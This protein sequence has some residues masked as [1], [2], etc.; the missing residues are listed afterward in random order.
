MDGRVGFMF[1]NIV[2]RICTMAWCVTALAAAAWYLQQG[3][4]LDT[5]KPDNV[6]GDVARSFL[7]QVLPGLLGVF[8][9]SL[10]ASVMSSCDAFMISSSGLFTEDI[11]RPL[12]PHREERHYLTVGRTA[13]LLVVVGGLLF[14]WWVPNVVVALNI[15]FKIAPMMGIVFWLGLFWRRATPIGAWAATIAGFSTWWLTT[16]DEVVNFVARLP[17]ADR[18]GM[19]SWSSPGTPSVYEPWTIDFYLTCALMAGVVGSLLSAPVQR[20]KLDTFYALIRTPIV[21]GEVV[22]K[23]CTLPDEASQAARRT[24]VSAWGLEIPI[25]SVTSLVG[26]V[27][28]WLSVFALIGGFV[29]LMQ[30]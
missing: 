2:K 5:I 15:W 7:P 30:L 12:R 1:G 29:W 16:N 3:V 9:A 27:V 11:Y 13:S 14:S 26:F 28:G 4:S 6:Y 23:P 10:L 21:E 19:I 8:L 18:W 22:R 24:H 17:M 20:N 25:P